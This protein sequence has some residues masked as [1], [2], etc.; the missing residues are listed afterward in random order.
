MAL[1]TGNEMI[2]YGKD[3]ELNPMAKYLI[4]KQILLGYAPDTGDTQYEMAIEKQ[5][6]TNKKD[7]EQ[8]KIK[9]KSLIQKMMMNVRK[10]HLEKKKN[11]RL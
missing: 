6:L 10:N 5:W 8:L 4:E 1:I 7:K 11:R 9:L 3:E 2:S